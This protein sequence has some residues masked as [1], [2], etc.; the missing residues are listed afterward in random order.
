MIGLTLMLPKGCTTFRN[1]VSFVIRI[2]PRYGWPNEVFQESLHVH[3][4]MWALESCFKILARAQLTEVRWLVTLDEILPTYVTPAVQAISVFCLVLPRERVVT[5]FF[6]GAQPFEGMGIF[7]ISLDWFLIGERLYLLSKW[8]EYTQELI[9]RADF[10]R[11]R[12]AVVHT[13]QRTSEATFDV[14]K[15]LQRA[16]LVNQPA[17]NIDF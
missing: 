5:N 9:L 4:S 13:F 17:T 14:P 12:W 6:G 3:M 16:R 7:E 2:R 10:T 1:T 11:F 8:C 15:L